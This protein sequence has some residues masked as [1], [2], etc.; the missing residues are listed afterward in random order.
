[1]GRRYKEAR[2]KNNIKV[3]D[4]AEIFGVSQPT[5]S[6]WEAGRQEPSIDTIKLM[7][8]TY[9]V[10]IDYLLGYDSFELMAA[11]CPIPKE[12]IRLFH[13]KP[14]WIQGRGWAL[15]NSREN[16]LV[17]ADDSPEKIGDD[18]ELYFAPP[19]YAEP[20]PI[21][22]PSLTLEELRVQ[23][24]VWVEPISTDEKLRE[25]LRGTYEVKG[26]YVENTRGSRFH[27]DCYTSSWLAYK[28]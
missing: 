27:F 3:I 20:N 18:T 28:K 16:T 26:E 24:T 2:Q 6:S 19:P 15:V 8:E 13:S 4:A 22:E 17:F 14:V 7:A 9:H 21:T 12:N 1:M 23:T 25:L 11:S 5:V 10:S